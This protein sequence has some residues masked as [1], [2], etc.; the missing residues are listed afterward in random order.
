MQNI[1]SLS[2]A[3]IRNFA[4]IPDLYPVQIQQEQIYFARMSRNTYQQSIFTDPGRVVAA[5]PNPL[6]L[7]FTEAAN[8]VNVAAKSLTPHAYIFHVAHC[9]STLL[10][11]AVDF[12][13][14]SLAIREPFPLRQLAVEY[15]AMQATGQSIPSWDKKLHLVL[16]L[17][18]RR[19]EAAE[20]PIIKANV[21]VNFIVDKVLDLSSES[22][23][24]FLYSSLETFLL[25]ALKSPKRR[26]WVARLMVELNGVL[27]QVKLRSYCDLSSLPTARAAAFL[28]FA[29]ILQMNRA[30]H[31]YPNSCSL[32]CAAFYQS[33]LAVLRATYDFLDIK[34]D[35]NHL[36]QLIEGPLFTHH[37]KVPA[38]AYSEQDRRRE[39]DQLQKLLRVELDDAIAWISPEIVVNDLKK[40]GS[41]SM[42]FDPKGN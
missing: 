36:N 9:G 2:D 24:I 34:V 12:P 8:M 18:G 37:S 32:D 20:Y 19:Y 17:L 39:A 27:S 13:G 6:M 5:H 22:K 26:Q 28:W 29:Q 7:T 4:V 16:S 14:K 23:S 1:D 10:S 11:R 30:L 25:Q 3:D 38:I 31:N 41:R 21:P 15:S 40:I 33:P 42:N 35:N